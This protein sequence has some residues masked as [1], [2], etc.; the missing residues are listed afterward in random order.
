MI[1]KEYCCLMARYNS[2]QN[3]SLVNAADTLS[4]QQR[5]KDR[6]AFFG[7][8]S[9][10]LHHIYCGDVLW[11]DRLAGNQRPN[12]NLLASLMTA[13]DWPTYKYYREQQDKA[14]IKWASEQTERTMEGSV[15]WY[16]IDGKTRTEK[17]RAVCIASLFNHQ[18]H[19]RGQVH[20]M[21][22]ATGAN[23]EATDLFMV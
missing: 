9:A 8:I 16:S 6:G 2:W 15:T 21:L 14:L 20:C 7:S 12:E 18:T 22:T 19:H 23:P 11:M 17:P 5:Q 4:N 10:T 3:R 1:S 13:P